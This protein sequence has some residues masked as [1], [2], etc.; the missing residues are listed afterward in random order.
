MLMSPHP[1]P[2][3]QTPD[4]H[5]P[6]TEKRSEVKVFISC[7]SKCN[8]LFTWRVSIFSASQLVFACRD[9]TCLVVFCSM[10]VCVCAELHGQPLSDCRFSSVAL[11]I[12][13]PVRLFIM[14]QPGPPPRSPLAFV[15]VAPCLVAGGSLIINC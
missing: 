11:L 7:R 14:R 9:R 3:P 8:Y 1:P 12:N 5:T 4:T 6:S 2:L 10:C 13:H 15:T